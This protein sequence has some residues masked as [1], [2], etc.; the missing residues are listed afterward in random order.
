MVEAISMDHIRN[1]LSTQKLKP[2]SQTVI[3]PDQAGSVLPSV[4]DDKLIEVP[5]PNILSELFLNRFKPVSKATP[6]CSGKSINVYLKQP[7]QD[8]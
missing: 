8:Q 7:S 3:F 5:L 1:A 6:P 4:L 2:L